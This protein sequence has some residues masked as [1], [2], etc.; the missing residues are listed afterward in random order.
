M[1]NDAEVL[2]LNLSCGSVPERGYQWL[3]W[4]SPPL[5]APDFTSREVRHYN[6]LN[7]RPRIYERF[8]ELSFDKASILDFANKYGWLGVGR[9]FRG[10]LTLPSGV[11][12][13]VG[14]KAEE[15]SGWVEEIQI[16]TFGH[17]LWECVS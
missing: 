3:D 16:L 13:I 14:T 9:M 6:P 5:L 4:V 17:H 10:N 8:L 7:T 15:I 12:G 2:D 11:Q 1:R